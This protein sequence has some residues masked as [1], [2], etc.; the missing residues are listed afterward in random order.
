ME[1]CGVAMA[2]LKERLIAY[3]RSKIRSARLERGKQPMTLRRSIICLTPTCLTLG[4]ARRFSPYK[5]GALLFR[6]LHRAI[7]ILSNPRMPIQIIFAGKAHPADDEGKRIIQRLMEWCRHPALRDRIAFIEDY[8]MYVAKLMV[9][10]VDVWLNHP[11]APKPA[12]PV[13]RRSAS[14]AAL[15]AAFWMAGGPKPTRCSPAA[16]MVSMAGPLAKAPCQRPAVQDQ[17][18]AESLYD[19]LEHQIA[20]LYYQRDR[21]GLPKRW[22]AHDE[23]I[24]SQ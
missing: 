18:D 2:I 12:A 5:R 6:D 9:Q 13:A 7:R 22:I 21:S 10:G 23:S 1:S 14:T 20:P 17:I 8:D 16:P 15:T 4:F 11:A 3:A 24:H 19:L